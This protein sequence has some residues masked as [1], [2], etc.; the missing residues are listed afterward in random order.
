MHATT[1]EARGA[2]ERA[3]PF[4]ARHRLTRAAYQ[5]MG[6]AGILPPGARVE[7]IDGEVFGMAPIGSFHAACVA[8]LTRCFSA[9]VGERAIV[10]VQNPI[11]LGAYSEPQPDCALL[12]YR[13]DFYRYAHPE[14]DDVLLIVEVADSSAKIDRDWKVPLYAKHA[15]NEV[16][17]LDLAGQC[18]EIYRQ[19]R[20][21]HGDYG[22]LLSLRDGHVTPEALADVAI[23][24]AA[25]FAW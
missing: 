11:G 8:R 4:A 19:P 10:W 18:L 17:L 25:L 1:I 14:P 21:E 24:V 5:R 15:I 22:R 2:V 20:P 23:D 6:E 16:W 7:L 12:R 9:Q 3:A 13:E